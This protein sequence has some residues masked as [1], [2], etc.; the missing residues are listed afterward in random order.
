MPEGRMTRRAGRKDGS[1]YPR[2]IE[3]GKTVT[4]ADLYPS[5]IKGR[6]HPRRGTFTSHHLL[7]SLSTNLT[8]RTHTQIQHVWLL[9]FRFSSHQTGLLHVASSIST[10]IKPSPA[11]KCGESCDCCGCDEGHLIL[12]HNATTDLLK[13]TWVL[14]ESEHYHRQACYKPFNIATAFSWLEPNCCALESLPHQL[15]SDLRR[16]RHTSP[17]RYINSLPVRTFVDRK[18]TTF[19]S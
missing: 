15:P 5:D 19:R 12:S 14:S 18:V 17:P 10:I 1:H 4:P 2:I 8:H 3:L 13:D 9:G 16:Y 11:P 6:R 7:T